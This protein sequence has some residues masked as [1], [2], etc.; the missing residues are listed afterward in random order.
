MYWFWF[1]ILVC[2]S[3][4]NLAREAAPR[5]ARS[6]LGSRRLAYTFQGYAGII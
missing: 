4:N 6:P 5:G 2:Y 1:V 3:M